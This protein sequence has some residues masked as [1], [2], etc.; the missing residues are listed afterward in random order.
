[1]F[2]V[3][4]ELVDA[5]V[6]NAFATPPAYMIDQSHN[7]KDPIEA[8]LQTVGELQ[9]AYTKALLVDRKGLESYQQSNDVLMAEQ[10]LKI[11]YETDVTSIV[12]EARRRKGGAIDPIATYRA[13]GYR[14][15][16]SNDRQASSYIPP[17]SI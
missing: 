6:D 2:L 13:S 7:I 8:L 11:A 10:S 3:F 12:A 14:L 16:M 15:A 5:A 1:L 4:N 9:R 17:Q